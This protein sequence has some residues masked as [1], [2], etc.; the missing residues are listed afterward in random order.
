VIDGNLIDMGMMMMI[1]GDTNIYLFRYLTIIHHA[2]ESLP[3]QPAP[4]ALS[5]PL[6]G[7]NCDDA[8]LEK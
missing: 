2:K 8:L 1:M 3:A 7:I 5:L 4:S 6:I